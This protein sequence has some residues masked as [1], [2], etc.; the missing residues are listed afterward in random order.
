MSWITLVWTLFGATSLALALIHFSIWFRRQSLVNHLLFSVIAALV[1]V[2]GAIEL[3]AMHVDTPAQ[4]ATMIRWG[5]VPVA[6]L[7]ILLLV[8]VH[9]RFGAGRTWLL[10]AA[11]LVRASALVPNFLIGDNL[12]FIKVES[13]GRLQVWGGEVVNVPQGPGNAW[14]LLGQLSYVLMAWYLLDVIRTVWRRGGLEQ[15]RSAVLVC[16]SIILF[17]LL[18]NAINLLVILGYLHLPFIVSITFA[19]AILVASYELGS[20]VVRAAFLAERLVDSQAQLHESEQRLQLAA[21][22]GGMGLWAW[23]PD[24][25]SSWFTTTGYELVGLAPGETLPWEGL[26]ARA[27]PEDHAAMWQARQVALRTGVFDCEYRLPQADGKMRWLVAKGRS[28][29]GTG[30]VSGM[31][32]GVLIDVTERRLLEQEAA[33]RRDE[34]THLSRVSVLGELSGSLAHELNQPLAAILSNAQAALRFL[35][36]DTPELG[37]VRDSLVQIVD[38]DKRARE[39]IRRLRALLRKEQV[40]HEVVDLNALVRETLLLANSDLVRRSVAV[41]LDLQSPLPVTTG[42]PIQLQQVFLN[43]VVNAC[44]AMQ[45]T[46]AQR[47]IIVTTRAMPG[48]MVEWSV[49]DNGAG[50]APDDLERIFAPF[51]TSKAEGIGLGLAICRTIVQAHGGSLWA[52]NRSEGGAA[53]HVMLPA[54]PTRVGATATTLA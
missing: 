51:V 10:I 17:I 7:Y 48:D 4:Y 30:G 40:P 15:R 25:G 23:D 37:E 53:L 13:L 16:G 3:I 46:P 27:H 14:T 24:R 38:N 42:D 1:P 18:H 8:Y 44:D 32:R 49:G 9:R 45:E 41:S 21:Q 33:Q 22:A 52:S 31:I 2:I 5:H 28:E 39:V 34:L 20:D 12:N 11:C 43:L 54:L 47:Q 35:D 26:V 50:I 29:A 36:R 19:G 6:L